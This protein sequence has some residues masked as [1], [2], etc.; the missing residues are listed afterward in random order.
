MADP[1]G[2]V[3]SQVLVS[4]DRSVRVALNAGADRGAQSNRFIQ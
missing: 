3:E 2:R 1:A 4:E